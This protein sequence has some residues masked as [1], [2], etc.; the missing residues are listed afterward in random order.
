MSDDIP[1]EDYIETYLDNEEL[2]T[3]FD[4]FTFGAD[5]KGVINY[6]K[7]LDPVEDRKMLEA[8]FVMSE[9]HGARLIALQKL[10]GAYSEES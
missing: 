7:A 9:T 4:I 10:T 5:S 6:V 2:E 3:Y 1:A 8:I